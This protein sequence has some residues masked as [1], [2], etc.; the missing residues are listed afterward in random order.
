MQLRTFSTLKKMHDDAETVRKHNEE[1]QKGDKTRAVLPFYLGDEVVIRGTEL[2]PDA[3]WLMVVTEAKSHVKGREGQL[4]RYVT[5]SGYEECEKER[6][7]VGHN[8]PAP[9]SLMLLN[10]TDHTMHALSLDKLPGIHDDP[11]KSV[12]EENARLLPT[13]NSQPPGNSQPPANNENKTRGI[14]VIS[15]EP[16]AVSGDMIWSADG[17]AVGIQMYSIDHKDRWLV[18]VDLANHV[19]IPQHRLSDAA[20]IDRSFNEF[21]WLND[22]RTLWYESEESGYAHL[23]IKAL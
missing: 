18:S 7:R 19:L 12:R 21:G 23:Y 22:N 16:D 17:G 6:L 1:L 8:P 14:W 10:L 2:S 3:R 15:D 20:W 13:A 4:T 11:L 9:Q 5:E